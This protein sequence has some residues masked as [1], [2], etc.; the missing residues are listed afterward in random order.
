[1]TDKK[2]T[3]DAAWAEF[4]DAV[5]REKQEEVKLPDCGEAFNGMWECFSGGN[6]IQN[7]YREGRLDDCMK[8]KNLWWACTRIKFHRDKSEG[9]T[10]AYNEYFQER[11]AHFTTPMVSGKAAKPVWEFKENYKKYVRERV[12]KA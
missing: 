4:N 7:Y 11:N 1:M 2:Q 5:T 3:D 12:L 9:R 10:Q 8:A 6:Q